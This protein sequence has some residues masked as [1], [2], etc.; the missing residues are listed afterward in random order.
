MRKF[1]YRLFAPPVFSEDEDRTRI[2]F[3][4]NV[5]SWSLLFVVAI[6]LILRSIQRQDANLQEVNLVLTVIIAAIALVLLLT[7]QG[8]VRLASI[9][10]VATVWIGLCYTAWVADGIRDVTFFGYSVP[11][12]MAGL[13]LGWQGAIFFTVV[14]ILSGWALAYAETYQRFFPTLDTPLHFAR[15]MSGIF[16]LIGILI[17]LTISNLQ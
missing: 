5:I 13:L 1:L 12:L 10:L 2:A 7:H 16:A 3:M 4:L 14:S 15:D 6:I 8:F 11:I 17:Y 9:L